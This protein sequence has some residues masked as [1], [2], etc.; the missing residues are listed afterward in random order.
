[1]RNAVELE[2]ESPY[3]TRTDISSY[4]GQQTIHAHEN[5]S[6]VC[7][8]LFLLLAQTGLIHGDPRISGLEGNAE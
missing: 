4:K 5:I 7:Q 3:L 6:Y 2:N 8:L 1:M